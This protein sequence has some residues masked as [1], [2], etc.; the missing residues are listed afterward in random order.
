[1]KKVLSILIASVLA[2]APL[3]LSVNA[4]SSK[5]SCG[6]SNALEKIFSIYASAGNDSETEQENCEISKIIEKLYEIKNIIGG[7]QNTDPECPDG[8]CEEDMPS[9]PDNE[10]SDT[11]PGGTCDDNIEDEL[12]GYE[13]DETIIPDDSDDNF[14]DL[15]D[16]FENMI[17]G[18][19]GN[20]GND[21]SSGNNEDEIV[22]APSGDMTA[23]VIDL[24]NSYRKANGLS[25]LS[26]DAEMA[27]AASIR[28]EEQET[29]FSHT[30]PDGTRCFTV[31]SECGISYRG[32]GENIAMGQ[33][34]A[35]EVMT[36]WMNSQGHREN[37]LNPNFTKIGVGLHIGS[38]GRY[39]WAQMF[40]Y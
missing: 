14:N 37:I 31:L 2:T 22:T 20:A 36:D 9:W 39:Y 25:E 15:K 16:W 17:N 35:E 40:I 21:S 33:T 23:Q 19:S 27:K 38:D 4:D 12:P 30:R 34:S 13:D 26:Y 29:V 18:G 3:S 10:D 11:C 8:S 7:T 28:A 5:T 1:M 24:V 6:I 32:A